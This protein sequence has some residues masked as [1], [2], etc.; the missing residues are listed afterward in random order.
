MNYRY[1]TFKCFIKDIGVIK[2]L[3]NLHFKNEYYKNF[4]FMGYESG[5]LD[6][7]ILVGD[8]TEYKATVK[9]LKEHEK[10]EFVI[11]VILDMNES[12]V[13]N[14]YNSFKKVL[15]EYNIPSQMILLKTVRI[16]NDKSDK[17]TALHYLH[18]MA[19]GILI[20]LLYTWMDLQESI[21]SDMKTTLEIK[22]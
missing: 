8:I 6:E 13:E 22:I 15:A 7:S 21:L 9:K 16:L 3:N 5:I 19:L 4:D 18:N 17:N 10:V 11:A 2:E 12:E 1:K 14:S 20:T